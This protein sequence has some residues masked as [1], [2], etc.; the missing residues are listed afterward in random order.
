LLDWAKQVAQIQFSPNTVE[1]SFTD[2]AGLG[3]TAL[4]DI[5]AGQ[6]IMQVPDNVALTI[7]A[8][9]DGPTTMAHSAKF[10]AMAIL[11]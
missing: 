7:E 5:D 10:V 4:Q 8:P 2:T 9:G 1:L 11:P 3:F 6:A